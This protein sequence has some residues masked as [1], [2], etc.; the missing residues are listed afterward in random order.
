MIIWGSKGKTLDLG[1][2]DDKKC[3]ICEKD[4]PFHVVLS[5]RY[6][7]LYWFLNWVSE[8]EYLYVCDICSRG[9]KLNNDEVEKLFHKSPIPFWHR[10]S[11][12]IF[13][14]IFVL[15]ILYGALF[16]G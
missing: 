15:V 16:A 10:W 5:Y 6:A 7:H 2:V 9:W 3:E 8:K 12:G 13:I 14:I 1:K 11:M 4:R